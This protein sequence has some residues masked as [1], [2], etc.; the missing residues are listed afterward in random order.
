MRSGDRAVNLAQAT[1]GN[2]V[3]QEVLPYLS[4]VGHPL[5]IALTAYYGIKAVIL[6]AASI[7]AMCTKDDDRRQ[8]CLQIAQLASRGLPW[9]PRLPKS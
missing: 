3:P 9:P 5:A 1:T 4:T 6:L 2:V 7:V 8:A